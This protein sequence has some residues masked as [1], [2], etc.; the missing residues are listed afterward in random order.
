M[1]ANR[2]A[3]AAA[4]NSAK[5]SNVN[6]HVRNA[7]SVLNA[8]EYPIIVPFVNVPRYAHLHTDIRTNH[9]DHSFL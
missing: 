2:T 5:T 1:N 3:N 4:K 6:R 9:S 8:F 7:D